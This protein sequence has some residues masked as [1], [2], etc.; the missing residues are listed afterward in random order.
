MIDEDVIDVLRSEMGADAHSALVD[1][2][3]QDLSS[4][5]QKFEAIAER[6]DTASLI[7]GLLQIVDMAGYLGFRKVAGDARQIMQA[8][9]HGEWGAV[10]TGL[11]CLRLTGLVARTL[12]DK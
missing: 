8:A 7:S 12:V 3:L 11:S 4:R 2:F 5:V 9:A 10:K 1:A 6:Q